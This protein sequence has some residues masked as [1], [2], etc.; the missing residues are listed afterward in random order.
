M[1][2]IKRGRGITPSNTTKEN[3]KRIITIN[4]TDRKKEST[5]RTR[6]PQ[7]LLNKWEGSSKIKR[8]S[9][10]IKTVMIKFLQTTTSNNSNI[11]ANH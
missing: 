3:T 7:I 2:Q 9:T 8:T 5:K 4:N 10:R 11:K 1:I 6:K